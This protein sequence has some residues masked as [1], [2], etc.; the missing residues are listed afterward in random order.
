MFSMKYSVMYDCIFRNKNK[1]NKNFEVFFSFEKYWFL[2]T[3]Y[4]Y[5]VPM[6]LI[7]TKNKNQ[8]DEMNISYWSLNM[9]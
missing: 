4:T 2:S 5:L 9:T 3:K 6:H 1:S 8:H 7:C